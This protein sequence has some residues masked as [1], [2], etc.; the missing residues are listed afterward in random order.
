[1][2]KTIKISESELHRVIGETVKEILKEENQQ[3]NQPSNPIQLLSIVSN[4][5]NNITIEYKGQRYTINK[6]GVFD[7]T[8]RDIKFGDRYYSE[9]NFQVSDG[10][11]ICD[12]DYVANGMLGNPNNPYNFGD[13]VIEAHFPKLVDIFTSQKLIDAALYYYADICDYTEGDDLLDKFL[14][15][16]WGESIENFFEGFF[17]SGRYITWMIN[18][19]TVN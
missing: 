17:F 14:K 2:K 10:Y 7:G 12:G 9:V 18:G 1:M 15:S 4:D 5:K 11:A 13:D 3:D 19:Q 6:K 8:A 16:G